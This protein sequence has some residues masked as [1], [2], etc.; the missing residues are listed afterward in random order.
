M[1]LAYADPPYPGQ[2]KRHYGDQDSYGGEVDH[3]ELIA[4]L[5]DEYPDGW[6][7]STSASALQ[8]VLSLCPRH[9]SATKRF[10]MDSG[11]RVAIWNVTSSA[12]PGPPSRWWW[13]WEPVIIR[14]GNW[15]RSD[16]CDL[17][18]DHLSAANLAG[19]RGARIVG[20]KPEAFA[21]WVFNLLGAG[22]GDEL[23]DLFPGSG[24]ITEAW[25]RFSRQPSLFV[26]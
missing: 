8:E 13:S 11:V 1:R 7:L 2:A 23:H 6:A 21:Y 3:A 15:R 25:E 12:P 5:E 19:F 14:G 16:P 18:R 22:P 24:A 10:A 17:V 26:A 4:R 20:E 9:R